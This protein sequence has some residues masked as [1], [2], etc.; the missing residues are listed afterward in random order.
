MAG[1]IFLCDPV[2]MVF[3]E[4]EGAAIT[5][6]P[7]VRLN[8][9]TV[10]AF[11][12]VNRLTHVKIETMD[13]QTSPTMAD[14]LVSESL[15]RHQKQRFWQILVPVGVGVVVILVILALVIQTA[16]GTQA[17]GPVSQ[18]ADASLIWLFLPAVL[19]ALVLALIL[20][21]LAYFLARLL[22]ILPNYTYLAQ[23]YVG[24]AAVYIRIGADK[25][26]APVIAVKSAGA[27]VSAF[28]RALSGRNRA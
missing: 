17:G 21:A 12:L 1:G 9:R 23:Q 26:A 20:C 3:F 8:L 6:Y 27:T 2:R 19:F 25:V 16:L 4:R 24:L 14:T 28:L 13:K 10:W 5:I 7:R 15:R 18:W 11:I 22:K